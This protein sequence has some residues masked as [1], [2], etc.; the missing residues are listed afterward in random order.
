MPMTAYL[1]GGSVSGDILLGGLHGCRHHEGDLV[2]LL[3]V[4]LWHWLMLWGLV[5]Y[6]HHLLTLH[7]RLYGR[8]YFHCRK[9]IAEI[10]VLLQHTGVLLKLHTK[11]L[12]VYSTWWTEGQT[13]YI[14]LGGLKDKHSLYTALGGL[15][16]NQSLY[17][18]WWTERQT[19]T[20]H[21]T[22]WTEGQTLYLSLIH[23]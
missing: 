12:T 22:W 9:S 20:V 6:C 3:V 18:T 16:D 17:C 5:P 4:W 15:K 10:I 1:C 14:A 23:I 19:L 7:R 21:C 2:G 11:T 13:L 8:G